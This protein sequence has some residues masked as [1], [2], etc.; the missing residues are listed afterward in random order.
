ML[1]WVACLLRDHLLG[2]SLLWWGLF[3]FVIASL[4]VLAIAWFDQQNQRKKPLRGELFYL[5]VLFFFTLLVLWLPNFPRPEL[6]PDESQWIA[7]ANNL[8]A[9]PGFWLQYFLP[10]NLTRVF[11]VLPLG[12]ASLLGGGMGYEGARV[13]A[14]ALWAGVAACFFSGTR[15]IFGYRPALA[16]AA[17]LVMTFGLFSLFDFVAYNSE[18]PLIFLGAASFALVMHGALGKKT[19]A[20]PTLA[21]VCIAAMPFAKE[22]GLPLAAVL[23]WGAL[24]LFSWRREWPKVAALVAG[25]LTW[26][27]VVLGLLVL[28]GNWHEWIALLN[29]TREYAG[30]GIARDDSFL[31]R[32]LGVL[33]HILFYADLRLFIVF[34]VLAWPWLLW[35][36]RRGSW[37]PTPTQFGLTIG[38]GLLGVATLFAISFPGQVF[39]HYGLLLVLPCGLLLGPVFHAWLQGIGREKAWNRGFLVVVLALFFGNYVGG[40]HG[41]RDDLDSCGK[42]KKENVFSE[43]IREVTASGDRLLIW[44]WQN[45][46][47]VE[48]GLLQGSRFI[49]PAF[50]IGAYSTKSENVRRYAEDLDFLQPKIILQWVGDDA[51]YF[52]GRHAI[53]MEAI[54]ELG[55]RLSENYTLLATE[56]NQ[57]LFLRKAP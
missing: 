23:A 13:V 51:F 21:G 55:R 32:R 45:S 36:A 47:F 29:V 26:M 10:S 31:V 14:V 53:Q 37:Q 28:Q 20:T 38:M 22:Q 43:R 17:F 54:P 56:G 25:G 42:K 3:Q 48:T 50:A 33:K 34:M 46:Y 44:G 1:S 27:L 2:T 49:H 52:R 11:T 9:A 6:N 8:A 18:V 15:L 30:L 41:V 40:H 57:R 35:R 24:L 5:Y 39:L 19:L 4:F 12:I 16:G 7:Q